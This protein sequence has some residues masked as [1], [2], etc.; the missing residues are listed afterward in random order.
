MIGVREN[1]ITL[2]CFAWMTR[3]DDYF[4]ICPSHFYFFVGLSVFLFIFFW[5]SLFCSVAHFLT[6]WFDLLLFN[7]SSSPIS[8]IYL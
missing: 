8:Y 5:N 4:K 2:I 6:G 1:S 3:D 7:F